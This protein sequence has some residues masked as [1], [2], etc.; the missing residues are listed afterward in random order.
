[1]RHDV[2]SVGKGGDVRVAAGRVLRI[3]LTRSTNGAK[4]DA[5]PELGVPDV[6]ASHL[7]PMVLTAAVIDA[8][9]V[10]V[11]P[12]VPLA[13]FLPLTQSALRPERR[14]PLHA[15]GRRP[16]ADSARRWRGSPARSPGRSAPRR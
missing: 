4:V 1:M 5:L 3:G 11:A 10:P 13:V 12:G 6:Q 8:D 7:E 16:L 15:R 2:C 14:S 9:P